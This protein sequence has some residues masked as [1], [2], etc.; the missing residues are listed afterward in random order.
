[1]ILKDHLQQSVYDR[2]SVAHWSGNVLATEPEASAA[3]SLK[4]DYCLSQAAFAAAAFA[5]NGGDLALRDRE[6]DVLDSMYISAACS[7][8]PAYGIPN[9]Q[10]IDLQN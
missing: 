10:P 6:V 5:D 8:G 7:H 9:L 3:G 2:A 4:T 1:V